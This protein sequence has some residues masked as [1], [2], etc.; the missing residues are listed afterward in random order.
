MILYHYTAREYLSSIM[1]IGLCRG[2]VALSPTELFNAVWLTN[3]KS[4]LGHGLTDGR[5]L[6]EREKVILGKP[7]HI[8]V[9]FLNK[10]A[11][12]ITVKINS[13]NR[14]LVHWPHWGRRKLT[15]EWY[16]ALNKAG[17]GKARTWFL[18]WGTISSDSFVE[19]LD[20]EA[21]TTVS[22][23]NVL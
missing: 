6:S 8:P 11:I 14:N 10:R 7:I 20:I 15:S 21:S 13:G 4:P 16:D 12:R 9:R 23:R 18:Y 22:S 3:D 5:D 19:V 1:E 2:E 17:G